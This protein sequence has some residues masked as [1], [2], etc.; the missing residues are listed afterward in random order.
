MKPAIIVTGG[1]GYIGSHTIVEILSRTGF[2]VIS[3]D[4]FCTSRKD[5]Y[6]RIARITGKKITFYETDLCDKKELEKIFSSH[7]SGL[8]GIIHFAALK[9]VPESVEHPL[10][11]YRNN[12]VSLLNISELC[13]QYQVQNLIFSS[14]CSVYGNIS[15]LPVSESTP[16]N[17]PESPYAFTKVIGEKML[18]ST[19]AV[20]P[21]FQVISLRYFNPVGAHASGI[22]GENPKNLTNN[23]APIITRVAA[24][25][26]KKITVFGNDYSTRDGTCIRDYVHVSDIAYAHVLALEYLLKKKNDKNYLLYNLGTGK[27][28]TVLEAIHA[29]EKISGKKLPY[30][31]G[32]RRAGD[33]EAIYSDSSLALKELGWKAEHDIFN[34]MET[35][36]K[37]QLNLE[38]ETV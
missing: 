7:A 21:S 30:E 6:D 27:G 31:T 23:L 32:P 5:T 16:L 36:W 17:T 2:E 1:A 13:I 15:Q 37:W 11:Y 18:S 22:I 29:F 38:K 26:L 10:R 28:V 14:S 20:N 24:G 3:I 19:C 4:N 8:A 9:S 12:I 33:V 25:Q 34:M 35:A